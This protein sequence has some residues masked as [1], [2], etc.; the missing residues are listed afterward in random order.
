MFFDCSGVEQALGTGEAGGVGEAHRD[1]LIRGRFKG[2]PRFL[3]DFRTGSADADVPGFSPRAA[4]VLTVSVVIDFLTFLL[5]TLHS[6]RSGETI[7]ARLDRELLLLFEI[8]ET[9]D[10]RELE[11]DLMAD[12]NLELQF[13]IFKPLNKPVNLLVTSRGQKNEH[14]RDEHVPCSFS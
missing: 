8:R 11:R 6:E 7:R 2:R 9:E 10:D 4:R 14:S 12:L 3:G 1:A 13:P 5:T